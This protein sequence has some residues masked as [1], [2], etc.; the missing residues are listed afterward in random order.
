M[1]DLMRYL[2]ALLLSLRVLSPALHAAPALDPD[3]RMVMLH[4]GLNPIDVDSDGH[5]DIVVVANRENYNA[6]GFEATS[7]YIWAA[8]TK[9]E[10]E[11]LQIVEVQPAPRKEHDGPDEVL[12]LKSGG[13]ADGLLTDFRLF[14]D[15]VHH[16]AVIIIA[17]REFGASFY[18]SQPVEFEYFKLTRNE[19]G[20]VGLP[21]LYFKSYKKSVSKG[22]HRDVN[23]A[24]KS[25]LGITSDGRHPPG[26]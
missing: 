15:A 3:L 11:R 1:T 18:D 12:V 21:V 9:H 10:P 5:A 17:N 16:T 14:V 13:G 7:I 22:A 4:N 25:E 20:E 2:A 6:H 24:F 26:E 23:E 8:A 19:E